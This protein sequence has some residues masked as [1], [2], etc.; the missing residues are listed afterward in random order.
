MV[1]DPAELE[2]IL[3]PASI[4]RAT[5]VNTLDRQAV[6]NAYNAILPAFSVAAGW[7]GSVA[8]CNPGTTS[9]AYEAATLQAANYYRAMAG[10]PN[11]A[12]FSP[13]FNPKNAQ[14]AL[15]SIAQG[16]LTHN[17]PATFACY[18]AGG[19]EAA[20]KSNLALGAAGPAAVDIYMDDFGAGNTAVGHRRWVLYPPQV[21]LGTGSNSGKFTTASGEYVGANSLW[22]IGAFG[23]RPAAPEFVAWPPAGFVPRQL[24]Y[25]RWSFSFP[26]ASFAGTTITMTRNG[27]PVGLGVLPI[28]D[29]FGDNT[30]VWEPQGL[31]HSAGMADTTY[32][33]TLNNV[34]VDGIART[35]AYDV[36]VIDPSIT[37]VL[38][39][40]G[41]K[42]YGISVNA[43]GSVIQTWAPGTAQL[44]YM[45]FRINMNDG[46]NTVLPA[47]SPLSPGDTTFTNTFV[48]PGGVY[49][50]VLIPFDSAGGKTSD[51]LCAFRNSRTPSG[52]PEDFTLRLNQSNVAT[53]TWDPPPG[54]GQTGYS[55]NIITAGAPPAVPLPPT[56]TS[57]NVPITGPACFR[58]D[59]IGRGSSDVLCAIPGVATLERLSK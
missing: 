10:L 46:T 25:D 31:T 21:A 5:A 58:L 7:N 8:G 59:A 14:S 20:G 13:S 37:P 45:V 15:M 44:G 12:P 16:E 50:Y 56:T 6:V 18:T 23:P 26:S 43:A 38:A 41:G 19:A 33:V 39:G 51:L 17:P 29:G 4:T 32:H 3:L 27:A 1:T 35:F 53:L 28:Q 24:A 36:I 9:A 40:F 47:A 54:G 57:A 30:I 34:V 2:P 11:V 42:G 52:A 55:L 49:C 22:V 48:S